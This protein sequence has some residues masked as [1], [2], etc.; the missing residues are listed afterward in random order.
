MKRHLAAIAHA[1]RAGGSALLLLV[2]SSASAINTGAPPDLPQ[3]ELIRCLEGPVRAAQARYALADDRGNPMHLPSVIQL[4]GQEPKYAAA[5]STPYPVEGGTRFRVNLAVSNDL[6]SWTHVGQLADNAGM[7]KLTRVPGSQWIV[8]THEQ[9]LGRR[10]ASTHPSRVGFKLYHDD[11]DLIGT[12]VRGKYL[13]P[14]HFTNL[15]GTPS[16]YSLGLVEHR[17]RSRLRGTFGL[18]FWN[19]TRDVNAV[20]TISGLF[21]TGGHTRSRTSTAAEYNL[22]F[23]RAGVSGN[24]GDRDTLVTMDGR[25]SVQEGNLGRAAASWDKW[26]LF[27]YKFPNRVTWPDGKGAIVSLRPRTEG[28]SVAFGNPTLNIVDRPDGSG[29]ALVVSYFLFHEGAAPGEAGS[30][31]YTCNI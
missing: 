28:G 1:S 3:D 8:L 12:R 22:R 30:L 23:M 10:A 17:G 13:L 6:L 2:A 21:D 19:G 29:K 15:N 7:A 14:P 16:V 5:Y 24:I 4:L 27:L 20:A 11:A 26:R 18:H 31:I 25:Y 9:W